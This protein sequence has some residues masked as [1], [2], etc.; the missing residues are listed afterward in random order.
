MKKQ[1]T[2]KHLHRDCRFCKPFTEGFFNSLG[3]PILGDCPH[4]PHKVIMNKLTGC[5]QWKRTED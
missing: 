5:K 1:T 3:E 4:V 2:E